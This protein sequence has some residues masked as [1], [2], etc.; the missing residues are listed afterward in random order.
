[1]KV[2]LQI[3]VIHLRNNKVILGSTGFEALVFTQFLVP[4]EG[5]RGEKKKNRREEQNGSSVKY[6]NGVE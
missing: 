4:A 1:M 5:R 3:K 6:R 2:I